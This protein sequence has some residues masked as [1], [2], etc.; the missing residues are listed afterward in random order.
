M[1]L[2]VGDS[3]PVALAEK[4]PVG[5]ADSVLVLLAASVAWPVR[6]RRKL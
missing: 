4:L 3:V 1:A 5:E 2:S 6:T